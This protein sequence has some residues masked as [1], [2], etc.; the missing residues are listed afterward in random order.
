MRMLFVAGFGAALVALPASATTFQQGLQ[1]IDRADYR[2]AHQA[3]EPL[4]KRGDIDA[5]YELG[6]LYLDGKGVP[7][8]ESRALGHFEAAA[9]PWAVRA[10]HKRGHPDAQYHA[11]VM[12]RDGVGT[13]PG[14]RKA[15][16]YLRASAR[17]GHA[18]AKLALSAMYLNGTGTK[19]EAGQAYVWA[20]LAAGGATGEFEARAKSGADE[21]AK[22]L[23]PAERAQADRTIAAWRPRAS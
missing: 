3:F 1:A 9:R 6:K 20:R 14:A 15:Y 23:S 13:V 7:K 21:A 17:Q 10:T 11:G 2:T 19:A 22:R 12:Y 16:E 4:A 5:H 18:S 8:D